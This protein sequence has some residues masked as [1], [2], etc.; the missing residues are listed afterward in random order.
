VLSGTF[1]AAQIRDDH[2]D[3][4]EQCGGPTGNPEKKAA[5][6]ALRG[7]LKKRARSFKI[8]KTKEG[9]WKGLLFWVPS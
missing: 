2:D 6:N 3:W 8:K 7:T 4:L 9:H 1:Y 5:M